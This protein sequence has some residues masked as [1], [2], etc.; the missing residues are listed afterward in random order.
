[1]YHAKNHAGPSR[2]NVR[3][4]SVSCMT[5]ALATALAP[6]LRRLDPERAHR[7]AVLALRLGLAGADGI[8]DEEAL[9]VGLS[10]LQF[11]N[12]IGIAAGFDKDGKAL[13]GLARLG[14]GFVEAGTVTPRAQRGN[15]R[16]RVFRLEEDGAVINRYGFNGEGFEAVK[17]RLSRL[18]RQGLR[19]RIGVNIGPNK[20]GDAERDLPRVA[21]VLSVQAG[22][23]YITINV[24]S[25]NTPGLRNLQQGRRL[26]S[27]LSSINSACP[28]RL[29]LFVKIAPDQPAGALEEVVE[30]CVAA[31]A[32]GL[33]VSNTTIARP[34]GLRSPARAEAGGL[35][36]RP[37]FEPSTRLLSDAY[38]L[39]RGRL[40]LIGCGGVRTGADVLVKIRAG[41]SLVQLYTAFAYEGPALVPRLKRELLAALRAEGFARVSDAIGT[42]A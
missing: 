38:R 11:P 6:I 15:P 7:L 36:G 3:T 20:D 8:A 41:A 18:P 1:M 26:A 12:P 9:S 37:L 42:A 16:P 39:A 27:L 5:P 14:F 13:R 17:A 22:V 28:G 29:P 40:V 34:A 33:I 25:P 30:T 10:H 35:S 32:A 23:D 31:G 19:S 24:S 4:V 2:W 21:A